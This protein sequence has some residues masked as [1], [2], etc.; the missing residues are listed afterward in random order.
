MVALGVLW[1]GKRLF[2]E[3]EIAYYVHCTLYSTHSNLAFP[4]T[5]IYLRG[6]LYGIS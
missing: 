6:S 1:R 2:E 3:E 5:L 4:S